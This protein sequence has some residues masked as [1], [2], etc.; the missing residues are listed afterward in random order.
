[1]YRTGYWLTVLVVSFALTTLPVRANDVRTVQLR[2]TEMPPYQML[3]QG[4]L[5]GISITTLSCVFAALD[6]P[7]TIQVVPAKRAEHDVKTATADGYFSSIKHIEAD[8]FARLS[9]PLA[10]EKWFL[11][12]RQDVIT[13]D[14]SALYGL[15]LGAIR[16]SNEAQWL[17]RELKQ[18]VNLVTEEEQLVKQ[19]E[20]GRIDAFI[21]DQR[22]LTTGVERWLNKQ[23]AGLRL[24]FLRY[25]E[26]G[27][28]FENNF[29]AERPGFLSKFNRALGDCN[30]LEITLSKAERSHL[31]ERAK[32]FLNTLDHD[33]VNQA[34]RERL[35][36]P[37]TASERADYDK[38]WRDEY[39]SGEYSFIARMQSLPVSEWLV[40]RANSIRDG[41]TEILV[42]DTTGALVGFSRVPSDYDQ[43]DEAK[44]AYTI[45]TENPDVYLSDITYDRSTQRFQAQFSGPVVGADGRLLGAITLGLDIEY[46]LSGATVPLALL[47]IDE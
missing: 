31:I 22:R 23:P 26:L 5:G 29:L 40:Q 3:E 45:G 12:S 15:R 16:G 36:Q 33:V 35:Q 47:L 32:A 2:T 14:V 8:Q 4:Q 34:L 27:V 6:T 42:F 9:A 19:L 25:A 24:Q 18:A 7:Y 10:M 38:R 28:Y 1:M 30:E 13:P 37:V 46:L 21:T 39:F 20:S 17:Q 44:F 41:F 11:V 43:S